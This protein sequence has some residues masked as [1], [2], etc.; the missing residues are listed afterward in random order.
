M[1]KKSRKP[2]PLSQQEANRQELKRVKR[3]ARNEAMI[4]IGDIV[5]GIFG[6]FE[7]C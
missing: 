2:Q 7:H 4:S 5:K 1:S 3:D 6:L